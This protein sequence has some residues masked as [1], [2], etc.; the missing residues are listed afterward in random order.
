MNCV[1]VIM[2]IPASLAPLSLLFG[3]A[4]FIISIPGE[5]GYAAPGGY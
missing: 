2:T 5:P 3:M 1:A 4:A